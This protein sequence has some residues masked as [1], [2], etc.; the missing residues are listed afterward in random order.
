MLVYLGILEKGVSEMLPNIPRDCSV[1]RI[2]C[3]YFISEG[4]VCAQQDSEVRWVIPKVKIVFKTHI[5]I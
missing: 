1:A 3:F 4:A 5:K 2:S